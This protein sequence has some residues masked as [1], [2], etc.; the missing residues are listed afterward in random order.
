MGDPRWRKSSKS[1]T[2]GSCVEIRNDLAGIRDSKDPD[3]PPLRISAVG[4]L[5]TVRAGHLD[6]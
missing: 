3:G 2:G 5:A 4:L 6:R 1:D